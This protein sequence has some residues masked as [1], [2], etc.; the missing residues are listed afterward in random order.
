MTA[1]PLQTLHRLMMQLRGSWVGP[2]RSL[3]WPQSIVLLC[4]LISVLI[5]GLIGVPPEA[6]LGSMLLV[7][8]LSV[9]GMLL[10][11][12]LQWGQPGKYLVLHR[13]ARRLHA[14]GSSRF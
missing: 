3:S 12:M 6:L 13:C 14:G 8:F 11:M 5:S 2:L 7:V 10:G 1:S 9:F 4:V